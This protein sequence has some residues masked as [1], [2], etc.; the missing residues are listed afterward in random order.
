MRVHR[1]RVRADDRGL[2]RQH[3]QEHRR[4]HNAADGW[5][6]GSATAVA[7]RS[8]PVRSLQ[9]FDTGP[10]KCPGSMRRPGRSTSMPSRS[11]FPAESRLRPQERH[12][13]PSRRVRA[14]V[15]GR[16]RSRDRAAGSTGNGACGLLQPAAM[17]R[18]PTAD[19]SARCDRS[20]C[21]AVRVPAEQG[22]SARNAGGVERG[23]PL[24]TAGGAPDDQHLVDQVDQNGPVLRHRDRRAAR[25]NAGTVGHP[26]HPRII[27][28]SPLAHT[29]ALSRCTRPSCG[30]VELTRFGGHPDLG[31]HPEEGS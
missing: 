29:A 17:S 22:A 12:I 18:C 31:S 19:R 7:T 2:T 26:S 1:R 9:H 30:E 14:S 25:H 15:G 6:C 11:P 3:Q 13:R 4:G 23:G 28:P 5:R 27:V 8:C 10:S 16:L 21:G 20:G 24:V